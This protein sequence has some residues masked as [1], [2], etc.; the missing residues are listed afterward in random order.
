MKTLLSII[1]LFIAVSLTA[2]YTNDITLL[3]EL[4]KEQLEI[5]HKQ[6]ENDITSGRS[7][8]I[9]GTAGFVGGSV[10]V[11]VGEDELTRVIGLI[12]VGLS[13]FPLNSAI[14]KLRIGNATK[15]RVEIHLKKFETNYN[16]LSPS[17]QRKPVFGIGIT[18]PIS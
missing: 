16:W 7:L 6:A 2:Q 17:S 18:I 12:A 5:I 9:L 13:Y 11:V 10:A 1:T 3:G 4:S 8:A 14:Y 15:R